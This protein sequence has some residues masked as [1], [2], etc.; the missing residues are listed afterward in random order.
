M[1]P[2]QKLVHATGAYFRKA[3]H[4]CAM[5]EKKDF[6]ENLLNSNMNPLPPPPKQRTNLKFLQGENVQK[7]SKG[8]WVRV[9]H[10]ISE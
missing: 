7:N 5:D 10:A 1:V 8:H 9:P 6:L 4:A 3:G 2:M